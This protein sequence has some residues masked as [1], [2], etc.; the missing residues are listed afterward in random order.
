[1]ERG[2]D[3]ADRLVSHYGKCALR[4]KYGDHLGA[5]RDL[6]LGSIAPNPPGQ[7]TFSVP[8]LFRRPD[9]EPLDHGRLGC[10][11]D[12]DLLRPGLAV[13]EYKFVDGRLGRRAHGATAGCGTLLHVRTDSDRFD[14][15]HLPFDSHRLSLDDLFRLN[16]KSLDS[17]L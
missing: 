14:A 17:R 1:V 12:T 11:L 15:V 13:W 9:P 8:Y 16:L 2:E 5:S 7:F 3:I 4:L 6:D 10:A